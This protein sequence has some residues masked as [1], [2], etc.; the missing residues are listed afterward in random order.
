M[1]TPDHPHSLIY[2]HLVIGV[3]SITNLYE[4]PGLDERNLT[5]KSLGDAMRLRNH[6]IAPLEEAD[7][8]CVT[9]KNALLCFVVA[10]GRIFWGRNRRKALNDF[11]RD[12]LPSYSHLAEGML[13]VVL[14]HAGAV[15]L[16]ELGEQPAA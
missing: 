13:R 8:E 2:D 12:V 14:V 5:M 9:R 3:G 6:L 16:P 4:L 15:I 10:G 1:S 11:V 7:N